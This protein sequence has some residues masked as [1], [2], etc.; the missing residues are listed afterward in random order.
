MTIGI[1]GRVLGTMRALDRYTKNIIENIARVSSGKHKLV[2][3]VRNSYRFRDSDFK[4][5]KAISVDFI[6]LKEVPTLFDHFIFCRSVK[7]YNLDVLFH[8]DNRSFLFCNIAQVTTIHDLIPQK[9]PNLVLSKDPLI[10]FRQRIYFSLQKAALEKVSKIVAV[11]KN[12]KKDITSE[13]GVDKEKITVIYEG[14]ENHFKPQKKAVTSQ[15]LERYKITAPYI[16]YLGGFGKHKNVLNLVKAF[17]K[18]LKES[19]DKE[20]FLVLGGKPGDDNSSGQNTYSEINT[21]AQSLGIEKRILFPGFLAEP[22]LPAIYS[23][24]KVF[25]FPS[26]Y[27]G[28]GFPPLEAMACGVP[29]V[30]SK[31]ASLPEVVGEATLFANSVDEIADSI[32]RIMT[33]SALAK[34]LSLKGVTQAKKFNWKKAG[35]ETLKVLESVKRTL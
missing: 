13:F 32:K 16:F 14:I 18:Y 21:V 11:S 15:T 9:F 20:T 29:V 27:E 5:P 4:L 3:F 19:E 30:V 33:N 17:E 2:I 25:V 22:D 34:E 7:K 1:D 28:F 31:K 12:T 10:N 26:K 8:P 35:R 6:K 23:G 24:A